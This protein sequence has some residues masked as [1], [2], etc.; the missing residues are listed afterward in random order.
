MK[1]LLD[2]DKFSGI[3]TYHEYNSL[4]NETTIQ[5]VQDVE[6]YIE[7][8]KELKK[9]EDYSRNGIKNEMWHYARIPLGIQME[10]LKKYGKENDPMR[11]G[12]EKLLFK[13]VNSPDYGYL[14]TT[15]KIHIPR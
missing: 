11:K 14:K 12:N 15:N 9:D 6:P 2:Y 4:T 8:S 5:S 7:Q 13:L 1:R 10:W 3:A